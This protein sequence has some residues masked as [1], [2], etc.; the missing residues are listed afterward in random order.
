MRLRCLTCKKLFRI[1]T[2]KQH[3]F[4]KHRYTQQQWRHFIRRQRS[5]IMADL[6]ENRSNERNES[7]ARAEDAATVSQPIAPRTVLGQARASC[8]TVPK[9]P[10]HVARENRSRWIPSEGA[11]LY[12][13]NRVRPVRQCWSCEQI[14]RS[15]HHRCKPSEVARAEK[16]K[17]AD[18]DLTG[19]EEGNWFESSRR[20]H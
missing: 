18:P 6:L 5:Q 10:S 19:V 16:R 4:D 1:E 9:V 17:M 13:E 2:L 20:R 12:D 14:S 11:P 3:C 8:P 15:P 7:D